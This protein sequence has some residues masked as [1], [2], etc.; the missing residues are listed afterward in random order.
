MAVHVALG[1]W[2]LVIY[3]YVY[4]LN[5]IPILVY[6][7]SLAQ[8]P[9]FPGLAIFPMVLS[10]YLALVPLRQLHFVDFAV[11]AVYFSFRFCMPV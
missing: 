8:S 4:E 9:P 7:W 11:I 1:R 3:V 2:V 5:A 10:S 6:L